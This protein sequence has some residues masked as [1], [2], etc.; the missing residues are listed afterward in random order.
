MVY[1]YKILPRWYIISLLKLNVL[2]KFK[3]KVYYIY[4]II[5]D[6][7]NILYKI[8][9]TNI[10]NTCTYNEIFILI[11]IDLKTMFHYKL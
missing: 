5:L 2:L 6:N 1:K 9:I 8:V 3:Y 10:T 7:N 4:Y 11:Y